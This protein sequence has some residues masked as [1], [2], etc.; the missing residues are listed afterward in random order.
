MWQSLDIQVTIEDDWHASDLYYEGKK[1][2]FGFCFDL[3][4]NQ[5]IS[6]EFDK[7]TWW[8]IFEIWI[9]HL[10]VKMQSFQGCVSD[11]ILANV[12]GSLREVCDRGKGI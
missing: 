6:A 3:L 5:L 10:V 8:Q 9:A 1:Q 4:M 11:E 12:S 7:A 2:C